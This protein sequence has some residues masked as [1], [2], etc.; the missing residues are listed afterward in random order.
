MSLFYRE[1]GEDQKQSLIIIHG[2]FGSSKNWITNAKELSEHI[3]VYSIDVRNHG[4]S[5]HTDTH[6]MEDLIEDLKNFIEE[7]NIQKPILLGHSM[8]GLN[9]MYFSL[10]YPELVSKLIV[11]DI[12]PKNYD[13]DYEKEFSCLNM[14]VSK[15]ESRTELDF[16]MAK[17]YDDKFI[18]QFLQMNLE[19]AE[20]GYVWKLNVKTLQNSKQA[21]HFNLENLQA[22]QN[23][24]LFILGSASE[25]IEKNDEIKIKNFFPNSKTKII[26]NAGH[27][28]HFTHQKE[29]IR[30]AKDFIQT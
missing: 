15:F 27:Y 17:L 3:K 9:V 30:F 24:A 21:L 29:F 18:R 16:E 20:K 10:K 13:V 28:L 5:F 12:A 23:D 6:K 26:E 22:I 14:D 19:K 7:K 4:E 1:Y 2:L 8:G 25:Y 11:L